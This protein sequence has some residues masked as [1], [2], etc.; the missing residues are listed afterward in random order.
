MARFIYKELL[1]TNT[2]IENIPNDNEDKNIKRLLSFLNEMGKHLDYPVIVN[3]GFRC[4]AVNKAV[5]GVP[6]SHHRLGYAADLTCKDVEGLFEHLKRFDYEID[7]LILYKKKN[8]VH[9]S[10]HPNKRGQIFYK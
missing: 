2:G 5:G 4:D 1:K 7:Q 8:F 10:V 6:T 3:S 9:V